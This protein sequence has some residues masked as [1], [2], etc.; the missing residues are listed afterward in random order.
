MRHSLGIKTLRNLL[1]DAPLFLV[2]KTK[3]HYSSDWN[4]AAVAAHDAM[5]ASGFSPRCTPLKPASEKTRLWPRTAALL[6]AW[7][8]SGTLAYADN[9]LS[10][11]KHEHGVKIS[12]DPLRLFKSTPKTDTNSAA[13]KP[14][15]SPVELPGQTQP[16]AFAPKVVAA[17]TNTQS[18]TGT[19]TSDAKPAVSA[20]STLRYPEPSRATEVTTKLEPVP[21][22]SIP[23]PSTDSLESRMWQMQLQRREAQAQYEWELRRHRAALEASRRQML[24]YQNG[25]S[26]D[27][28]AMGVSPF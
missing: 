27:L 23:A 19:T 25:V 4:L 14:A 11:T 24:Q 17:S 8:I 1:R 21:L 7:L 26:G 6:A 9:P 18:V 12:F 5:P 15:S 10:I 20:S 16:T 28:G 13:A 3:S 22:R 2:M